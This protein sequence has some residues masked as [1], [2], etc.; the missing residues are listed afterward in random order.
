MKL[1]NNFEDFISDLYSKRDT[2][3]RACIIDVIKSYATTNDIYDR[4]SLKIASKTADECLF[5][6]NKD[7]EC[8]KVLGRCAICE[9]S[10]WYNK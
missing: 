1:N 4:S 6:G 5:K 2:L 3:S 9:H 10:K 8:W 7:D